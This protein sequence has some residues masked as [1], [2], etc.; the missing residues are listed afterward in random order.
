MSNP[1]L[2][3]T[4]TQSKTKTR[5]AWAIAI[6]AAAA[7]SGYILSQKADAICAT[8]PTF[9]E[10]FSFW[11]TGPQ[12]TGQGTVNNPNNGINQRNEGTRTFEATQN[13]N[14]FTNEILPNN[15]S[16]NTLVPNDEVT[17]TLVPNDE[18]T[19]TLVPNDEVNNSLTPNPEPSGNVVEPSGGYGSDPAPEPVDP[20]IS[21]GYGSDPAPTPITD[22]PRP[23]L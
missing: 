22:E 2:L 6:A 11:T 13:S 3:Q 20:V 9:C 21:G 1:N 23:A 17:N 16:T 14:T 19:N 5:L 12:E 18:I 7:F 4:K 15:G 8:Y 10:R